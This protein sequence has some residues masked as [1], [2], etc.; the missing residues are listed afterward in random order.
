MSVGASPLWIARNALALLVREHAA[1]IALPG[2]DLYRQA[3]VSRKLWFSIWLKAE[4]QNGLAQT[5]H[6]TFS[7]YAWSL[8]LRRAL[9]RT[10]SVRLASSNISF[11]GL[12][13]G[14]RLV[15]AIIPARTSR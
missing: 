3:Q 4:I 11:G 5:S 7:R 6:T 2:S 14:N 13:A 9:S 15:P 10:C 1:M 8:T 12:S